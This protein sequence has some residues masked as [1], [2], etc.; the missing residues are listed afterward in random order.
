MMG[1]RQPESINCNLIFIGDSISEGI[2]VENPMEESAPAV[3]GNLMKESGNVRFANC[4]KNGATT[5]DFLPETRRHYLSVIAA[6]DTLYSTN[7]PLV[8]SIMI[9]TNDSAETG[10]AGAPVSPDAYERN[11]TI[12][13]DSLHERYPNSLF[14]LHRPI[15]YSPNT[16]NGSVYMEAGLKRLQS[17]TPMLE[18]IVGKRKYVFFGDKDAYAFFEKNYEQCVNPENGVE[19]IFYLH[20]NKEGAGRLGAFWAES[21]KK[22]LCK[23]KINSLKNS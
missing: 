6:A 19:G 13:I 4:G 8:F 21:L 3:A 22:D 12:I 15:W 23:W 11:L 14:V 7:V 1:C 2:G 16:H 5:V 20:P 17:Y 18:Q 9:G 10:P